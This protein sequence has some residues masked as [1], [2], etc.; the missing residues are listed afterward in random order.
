MLRRILSV[1]REL[2]SGSLGKI[3]V[4]VF[5]IQDFVTGLNAEICKKSISWDFIIGILLFNIYGDKFL[6]DKKGNVVSRYSPIEDPSIMED[7]IKELL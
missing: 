6:V 5:Y 1:F 3:F 4:E 7:E 2:I